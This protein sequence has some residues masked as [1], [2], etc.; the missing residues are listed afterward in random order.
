QRASLLPEELVPVRVGSISKEGIP[1]TSLECLP[2][3]V[4]YRI[5]SSLSIEDR[6]ALCQ[7]SATM[8]DAIEH[9]DVVASEAA[10]WFDWHGTN[11]VRLSV[12]GSY[13]EASYNDPESIQV[14][15]KDQN[16]FF[17]K[18]RA[19][20]LEIRCASE[21]FSYAILSLLADRIDF[22]SI[23]I[24]LYG[25]VQKSLIRFIK[26]RKLCSVNLTV[27]ECL[28]STIMETIL[29]LPT[30]SGLSVKEVE[31]DEVFDDGQ[32]I[33]ILQ[34]QHGNMRLPV[35]LADPATI[36]RAI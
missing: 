34:K 2:K 19:D 32:L 23:D 7:C 21:D 15:M 1:R 14:F 36:S 26:G 3:K 18:I 9:S 6:H 20:V 12:A 4:L 25:R 29:Q 13:I 33:K 35:D 24:Q 16:R 28:I 22:R 5:F 27:R 30:I 31:A 10:L 8:K 11:I 17:H